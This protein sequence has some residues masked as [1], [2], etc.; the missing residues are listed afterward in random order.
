MAPK[1][2]KDFLRK[3]SKEK[4]IGELTLDAIRKAL[5]QAERDE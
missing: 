4:T 3:I 1:D 2:L 5:P